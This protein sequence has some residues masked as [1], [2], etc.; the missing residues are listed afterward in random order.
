MKNLNENA[1][2]MILELAFDNVTKK[3]V[4]NCNVE[5]HYHGF[6]NP[7]FDEYE[8]D[9]LIK[10]FGSEEQCK[11]FSNP[12]FIKKVL[13]D[14]VEYIRCD[15]ERQEV[16]IVPYDKEYGWTVEGLIFQHA[17]FQEFDYGFCENGTRLFAEKRTGDFFHFDQCVSPDC[18]PE[19][20]EKING[21]NSLFFTDDHFE[22]LENEIYDLLDEV[23]KKVAGL[24]EDYTIDKR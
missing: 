22:K 6:C 21:T 2:N 8:M 19:R 20:V 11:E 16:S 10:A 9:K 4:G 17:D 24:S 12:Y 15:Y 7:S 14:K 13:G 18:L 1:N 5:N 23:K 3:F